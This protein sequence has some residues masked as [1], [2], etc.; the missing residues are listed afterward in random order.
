M[1]EREPY[2]YLASYPKSGNTWCRVFITELRRLAGSIAPMPQKQLSKRNVSSRHWLD[3]QLGFGWPAGG[4]HRGVPGGG[5][6][7]PP[8]GGCGGVAEPFLLLGSGALWGVFVE[9]GSSAVPLKQTGRP[10]GAPV[11]GQLGQPCAELG[12]PAADP[13][14]ASALRRPAGATGAALPAAGH[15]SRPAC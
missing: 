15:L 13:G 10:T 5:G 2:W 14:A 12:G 6:G 7:D 4:A 9:R 1:S 3:D 8:S 11:H